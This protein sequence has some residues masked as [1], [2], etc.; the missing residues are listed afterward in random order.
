MIKATDITAIF[1]EGK[2]DGVKAADMARKELQKALLNMRSALDA[3]SGIQKVTLGKSNKDMVD[4]NDKAVGVLSA[5]E[6]IIKKF[7]K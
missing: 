4:F 7:K 2:E 1:N 5:A 6:T 3:I